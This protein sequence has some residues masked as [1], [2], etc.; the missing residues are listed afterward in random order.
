[1]GDEPDADFD[2]YS[3]G[4]CAALRHWFGLASTENGAVSE[5]RQQHGP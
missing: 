1:M 2:M 4:Q 3:D 5:V